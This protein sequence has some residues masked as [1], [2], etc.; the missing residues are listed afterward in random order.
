MHDPNF[1]DRSVTAATASNPA[2][3]R[4]ASSA[5]PTEAR[6]VAL[7]LLNLKGFDGFADTEQESWKEGMA[8]V[9]FV[10]AVLVDNRI[11]PLRVNP[12]IFAETI[13]EAGERLAFLSDPGG[14]VLDFES[15]WV[16]AVCPDGHSPV[17]FAFCLADI[18]PWRPRL[19]VSFPTETIREDAIALAAACAHLQSLN[20]KSGG[21]RSFFL[22]W[23]DA[24]Q[25][26][27]RRKQYVGQLIRKLIEIG[28]LRE[29]SAKVQ[30]EKRLAKE[31]QYLGPLREPHDLHDPQDYS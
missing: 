29:I 21:E 18:D 4:N 22:S 8:L 19:D 25:T 23:Q 30:S 27:G 7:V 17:S 16:K 14:L 20:E 9:R 13:E 5:M 11:S 2:D 1:L 15:A 28:V 12:R 24:A 3:S 6:I 31:Y 26:L 10:Q